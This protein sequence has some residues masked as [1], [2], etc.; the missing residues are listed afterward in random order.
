MTAAG[1]HQIIRMLGL[2]TQLL[3]RCIAQLF[4]QF[5]RLR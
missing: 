4:L 1:L 2:I 3:Q 5:V